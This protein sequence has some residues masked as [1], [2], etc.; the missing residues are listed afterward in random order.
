VW[1]NG[2]ISRHAKE[3]GIPE[4]LLHRVI[5]AE[6]NYS[7][8]ASS[9]GNYGLMQIR[10]ATAQG[11]GYSGASMGLLDADTNLTYGVPYLANA[12]HIA[13]GDHD[14]AIV[15]YKTGYYYEAKRKGL[16][17]KLVKAKPSSTTAAFTEP[18]SKAGSEF[19][20]PISGPLSPAQISVVQKASPGSLPAGSATLTIAVPEPPRRPLD[21]GLPPPDARGAIPAGEAKPV[22]GPVEA[23]G[24]ADCIM[25]L[26]RMGLIAEIAITPNATNPACTI[27]TPVRLTSLKVSGEQHPVAFPERPILACRLADR[28]GQ[29]LGEIAVPVIAARLTPLRAVHT[30]PGYDCRN[31][32]RAASGKLSAHAVGH[33]VDIEAFKLGSGE[34][35]SITEA[36]DEPKRGVLSSL[37]TAAC[38]WFTT[39][40]G[41]GSDAAHATH[42]H[43]DIEKHG[44]SDNYRLCGS[45]K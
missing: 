12:Y 15:L 30:G 42:W 40:L 6:S 44:S 33:A 28:F 36:E 1:L 7:P 10:H 45:S 3:F 38:G 14:R 26:Q 17:D 24:S 34:T 21:L 8:D 31:R 25:R 43:F 32:N 18:A 11:M 39:I 5:R 37:R 29:W 4:A 35:L 19:G 20:G 23:A 13:G 41:P 22:E 9:G 2:L 27:E 16:L